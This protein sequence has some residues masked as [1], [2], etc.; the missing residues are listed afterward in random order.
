MS[1][2][3]EFERLDLSEA[4]RATNFETMLHI[5]NVRRWLRRVRHNI[6]A[7]EVAH[8][9]SKLRPPEVEVFTEFTNKLKGL[10]YGSDEYKAC[11]KA[12]GPAL[13]H[14][15]RSNPSHHPEGNPEGLEGMNLIDMVEMLCDWKAATMR[16]ADGDIRRSIKINAERFGMSPQ[17]VRLFENTVDWM[18]E[19]DRADKA[20][21]RGAQVAL[22]DDFENC[23]FSSISSSNSACQ[24]RPAQPLKFPSYVRPEDAVA[25]LRGYLSHLQPAPEA[26]KPS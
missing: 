14:H 9:Q 13:Q 23:M 2:H 7:R 18:G 5:E 3:E 1:N 4:E 16:H 26:P 11:L 20:E 25:W 22:Q 12:M 8:D 24:Q 19:Y 6:D 17:L 21:V 15:Y 10:T